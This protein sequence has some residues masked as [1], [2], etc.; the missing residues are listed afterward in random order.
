M[1]A[2]VV[3]HIIEY[4]FTNTISKEVKQFYDSLFISLKRNVLQ[5]FVNE[6]DG[7]FSNNSGFII[8]KLAKYN[9]R[10]RKMQF[11]TKFQEITIPRSSSNLNRRGLFN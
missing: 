3:T 10:G 9:F 1:I 11:V 4:I 5:L 2:T 8:K 6:H 7:K